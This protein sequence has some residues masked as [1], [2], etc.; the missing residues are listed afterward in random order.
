MTRL[1]VFDIPSYFAKMRGWIAVCAF[2]GATFGAAGY[3]LAGFLIGGLLGVLTPAGA[4]LLCSALVIWISFMAT[5]LAVWA[6]IWCV[7]IWLLH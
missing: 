3:G 1:G 6:V 4:V 5:Y 2:L 7:A